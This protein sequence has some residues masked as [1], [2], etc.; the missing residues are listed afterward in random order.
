MGRS[1]LGRRT[2]PRLAT[3]ACVAVALAAWAA[4]A[5][6]G[7]TQATVTPIGDPTWKPVDFHLFSGT[8]GTAAD[9]F[10]GVLGT[11]TT[12]LP[13][14]NHRPHPDLGVGPGDPHPPPYDTEI[15]QGVAA[16]FVEKSVFTRADFSE[17]RGIFA[18]FM[19]VPAPGATGRSPD[20]ASGPIIPNG[21]FPFDFNG[22][23]FRQGV[24]F[25]S[26]STFQIPPLDDKLN[27]PFDVQGHSH[28]PIFYVDNYEFGFDPSPPIDG[29]YE[30]RIKITDA[31]GNGYQIVTPF[32]VSGASS[33]PL[34]AAAWAGLPV[35]GLLMAGATAYRRRLQAGP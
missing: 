15:G 6:A 27:P 12:V 7:V 3:A 17:P 23:T 22:D 24:E 19:L 1:W 2:T 31:Q 10:A 20:F 11:I 5:R 29:S 14:P 34:P 9:N 33:V 21:L 32:Q 35:L 8:T 26:A 30:Y 18:A 16:G 25:S 4:P 28:A 13:P